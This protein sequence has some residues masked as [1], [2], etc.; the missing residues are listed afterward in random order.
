MPFSRPSLYRAKDIINQLF[1]P[2]TNKLTVDTTLGERI[3]GEDLV[4]DVQKVEERFQ[5]TNLTAAA[6]TV[7]KTGAG[8]LHSIVINATAAGSITLYDNTA[9]SGVKIGTLKASIGENTY[10]YNGT[11]STGLTVVLAAASDVTVMWR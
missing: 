9:A 10:T 8:V 1:N 6:T 5:P 3:A 4:N 11:F 2:D 7:I